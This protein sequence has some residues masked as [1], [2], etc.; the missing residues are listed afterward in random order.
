MPSVKEKIIDTLNLMRGVVFERAD[1]VKVLESM[2][3]EDS[4]KRA[5]LDAIR[6][7]EFQLDKIHYILILIRRDVWRWKHAINGNT[8]D[9][10]KLPL[11]IRTFYTAAL[12]EGQRDAL[13]KLANRL[14]DLVTPIATYEEWDKIL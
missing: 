3:P 13:L 12:N 9:V 8:L 14:I 4:V 7:S 5:A 11:D 2:C 10:T 6:T 1:S